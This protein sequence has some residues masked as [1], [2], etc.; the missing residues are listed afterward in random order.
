MQAVCC[1]VEVSTSLLQ[2]CVPFISSLLVIH[3]LDKAL[4][5][6]NVSSSPPESQTVLFDVEK[7]LSCMFELFFIVPG[8]KDA[9]SLN[10]PLN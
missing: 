9:E 5:S 2:C 10:A 6:L 4:Y 3:T 7:L 1:E 8:E